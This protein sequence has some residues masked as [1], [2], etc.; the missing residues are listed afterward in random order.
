MYSIVK[1][2]NEP[3]GLRY[4]GGALVYVLL[5]LPGCFMV[6]GL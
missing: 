4:H 5:S 2:L 3:A 1:F 6:I